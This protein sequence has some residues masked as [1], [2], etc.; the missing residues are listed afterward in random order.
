MD[1][2]THYSLILDAPTSSA[3]VRLRKRLAQDASKFAINQYQWEE[4]DVQL[5]NQIMASSV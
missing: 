1:A 4:L 5:L 2:T 3:H